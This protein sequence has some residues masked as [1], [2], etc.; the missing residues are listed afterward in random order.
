MPPEPRPRQAPAWDRLTFESRQA[1]ARDLSTRLI[2]ARDA[3]RDVN[4]DLRH[5]TARL[6]TTR[7][8]A[9]LVYR[10]AMKLTAENTR[11]T[12]RNEKL[13]REIAERE[14][15]MR[16]PLSGPLADATKER[17]GK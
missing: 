6:H 2:A 14:R 16:T 8:Q 12:K 11:L 1:L 13:K 3:L 17:L 4:A 10:H 15:L 7:A 5:A 9:D